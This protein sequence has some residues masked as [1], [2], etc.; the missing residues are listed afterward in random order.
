MLTMIRFAFL[1][2]AFF[3]PN[4]SQ[5]IQAKRLKFV[6]KDRET[7]DFRTNFQKLQKS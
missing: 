2:Q 4:I 6:V 5:T 7:N 1:L 3:Q